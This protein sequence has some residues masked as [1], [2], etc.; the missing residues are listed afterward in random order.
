[1]AQIINVPVKG[2]GGQTMHK[3]VTVLRSWQ[4]ADGRAVYLHADGVYGHIDHAPVASKKELGI[5]PP[6]P[7]RAAAE[8]WWESVGA[9]LAE[10]FY[11][12]RAIEL[13][14]QALRGLPLPGDVTSLDE[15]LYIRRPVRDR[16]RSSFSAP[17]T[18][19]TFFSQRPDWWGQAG[20]V[21]IGEWRYERF[22]AEAPGPDEPGIPAAGAPAKDMSA[23]EV[24]APAG[25]VPAAGELGGF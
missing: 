6:G 22:S 23:E 16:K 5:I 11:A 8:L 12:Q 20:V 13:E 1:M 18:W 4:M 7:Q 9:A 14:K 15:A 2:P 25:E 3:K 19:Q 10:S 17:F 21:E 24:R